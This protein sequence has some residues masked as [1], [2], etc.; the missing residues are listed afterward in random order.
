MDAKHKLATRWFHWL[1]FPILSLMIFSGMLIYWA[2]DPYRIGLGSVTIF[3][4]FPNWFY[5]ATG[6]GQ[7]L[8]FGMAL[9]FTLAW[10]FTLNGIAYVLY[11]AISGEWREL[12]P[13][14]KSFGEALQ[15]A[16]HDMGFKVALPPQGTYNA[17]QRIT[18]SLIVVMGGCSLITGLAIFK[19]AQL[20]W[21]TAT[22]G[23]YEWA[24]FE[25]FWL[26]M[27]YVG[28]FVIH[29]GQVIRAGWP[30]FRSMVSGHEFGESRRSFLTLGAGAAGV[31]GA[32][33]WLNAAPTADEIPAPLRNVL[34]ANEKV[35]RNTIYGN[36]HLVATYPKS[37]IGLLKKNGDIGIDKPIDLTTWRLEAGNR[38]FTM[39]DIRSL[40]KVE[41]IIDFKCVEGWSVVTQFAGARLSDFTAKFAPG[42]E[43][44][45]YVGMQTP[46]KEYY[47][48]IDTPSALHPQTLLAYE[49]NGEPLT[50][51][52]GAPLRLVIPV[53]YGIKNLKRIAR[54][55]YTNNRPPD[56]W[57]EQ[58]YDWYAGL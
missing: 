12:V 55:E 35:V 28:F 24:R 19:P 7:K 41:Q 18:Y 29:I 34:N 43:K 49:M 1:N 44:F 6:I 52:H 13:E 47:V 11:T 27:G 23:G 38:Q 16:M 10:L 2:Y 31:V 53:K 32:W 50:S 58:G 37:D 56:Y 30:N 46:D 33:Y 26:T 4:F 5:D 9:H 3:H 45:A 40:P 48:S 8:A 57:E 42:A 21:L 51:D 20:H 14:K 36:D 15:V 25:H 54:I 39:D 22:L 17:A